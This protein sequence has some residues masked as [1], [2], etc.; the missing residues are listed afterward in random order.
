VFLKRGKA[1]CLTVLNMID[2]KDLTL[3]R[4]EE[5]PRDAVAAIEVTEMAHP[6][7]S[8]VSFRPAYL[9][10]LNCSTAPSNMNFDSSQ[11][12]AQLAAFFLR[13]FM[14]RKSDCDF[15][16]KRAAKARVLSQR[17]SSMD[18]VPELEVFIREPEVCKDLPIDEQ[19]VESIDLGQVDVPELLKLRFHDSYYFAPGH[20][21]DE[22]ETPSSLSPADSF[23]VLL[24]FLECRRNERGHALPPNSN[25]RSRSALL[26]YYKNV[27][28]RVKSYD[29]LT[30]TRSTM[31]RYK[32]EWL[33]KHFNLMTIE[34][35]PIV[36]RA[37]R[38]WY[39]IFLPHES[40]A[41]KTLFPQLARDIPIGDDASAQSLGDAACFASTSQGH[42][43]GIIPPVLYVPAPLPNRP[44]APTRVRLSL[45]N[46]MSGQ[47]KAPFNQ[48]IDHLMRDFCTDDYD[49]MT[50]KH[51]QEEQGAH[52][53]KLKSKLRAEGDFY[54]AAEIECVIKRISSNVPLDPATAHLQK[55]LG[56]FLSEYRTAFCTYRKFS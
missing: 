32:L 6:V 50:L 43:G 28:G 21:Q 34:S 35:V 25:F 27:H 19:L 5:H 22:M 26:E 39:E 55:I 38:N 40:L 49:S 45:D 52:Y 1:Q 54:A 24:R 10:F 20:P 3:G 51:Q 31:A 4:E 8:G 41:F 48:F 33:F 9:R 29:S 2:G 18:L 46:F 16:R 56:S 13:T 12:R 17:F 47:D 42:G 36:W 44:G 15:H 23:I 37:F 14:D 53:T 11:I 7:H 30:G